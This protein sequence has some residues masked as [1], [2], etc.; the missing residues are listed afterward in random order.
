MSYFPLYD[1]RKNEVKVDLDLCNDTTKFDS[2]NVTGVN[3]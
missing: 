2:K 3:T 1:H